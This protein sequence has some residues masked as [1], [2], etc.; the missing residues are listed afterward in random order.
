MHAGLKSQTRAPAR[1]RLNGDYILCRGRSTSSARCGERRLTTVNFHLPRLCGLRVN[2][3][4]CTHVRRRG[5]IHQEGVKRVNHDRVRNRCVDE[6]R[7][8][9]RLK[10]AP[11]FGNREELL[12][13]TRQPDSLEAELTARSFENSRSPEKKI[14]NVLRAIPQIWTWKFDCVK[15]AWSFIH[16]NLVQRC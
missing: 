7:E 3:V 4:R 13:R 12:R 6:T 10:T 2:T 16:I 11:L 1:E 14:I 5:T 15:R 8:I 9:T